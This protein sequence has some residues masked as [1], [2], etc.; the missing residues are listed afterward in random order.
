MRVNS[1]VRTPARA[2]GVTRGLR[3]TAAVALLAGAAL[4]GALPTASGAPSTP[5][6]APSGSAPG[7]P[8]LV[9]HDLGLLLWGVP[10]APIVAAEA[11]VPSA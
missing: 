5:R 10:T 3:R 6:E 11:V 9:R 1:R 7:A 2:N 4:T 8:Q